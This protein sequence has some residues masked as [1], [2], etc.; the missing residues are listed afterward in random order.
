MIVP[1]YISNL[2]Y[3]SSLS[4]FLTSCGKYYAKP[5]LGKN[6]YNFHFFNHRFTQ[7]FE[8]DL[9]IYGDGGECFNFGSKHGTA[10]Y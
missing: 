6:Y 8:T 10:K 3:D 7:G 9:E 2:E 4:L 1:P 5:S